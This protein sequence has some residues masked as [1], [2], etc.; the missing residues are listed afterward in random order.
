MNRKTIL[1]GIACVA[2]VAWAAWNFL[3]NP[4]ARAIDL[5]PYEAAG[6][7]TGEETSRL[8]RGRGEVVLVIPDPGATADPVMEAQ[9]AAFRKGLGSAGKARVRAVSTVK[10]DGFTA[11]RTGGAMPVESLG[12]LLKAHRGV[13]AMVFFVGLPPCGAEL[14][15]KPVI[16]ATRIVV[17]TAP[18]PWYG[19]LLKQGLIDVGIVSR[20]TGA[21]ESE[22]KPGTL[23]AVFDREYELLRAP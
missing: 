10:I 1:Q 12:E 21:S 8:I 9:V 14:L 2:L 18:F 7:V 13:D 16:G 4:D 11:M 19:D 22:T 20:S 3:R 6:S 5:L 15:G 17:L 23:R